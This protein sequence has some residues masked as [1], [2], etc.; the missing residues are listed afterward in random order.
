MN[1]HEGPATWE[2][3]IRGLLLGLALGDA[4]G[5][6]GSDI[7]PTG[8][9]EAGAATQ[10]AAWTTEGLLR[11]ATRYGGHVIGNPFDVVHYAYQRWATLRREKAA[12]GVPW[13]TNLENPEYRG[14]L[15]DVPAMAKKRGSSPSTIKALVQGR[16][17][18]SSGCQGMLRVLPFAAYALAP[19]DPAWMLQAVEHNA[20][21]L[22]AITHENDESWAAAGLATRLLAETLR[23][24]TSPQMAARRA[25][26]GGADRV[27][28][29]RIA[30][31]HQLGNAEPCVPDHLEALAPKKTAASALAGGMYVALSFPEPDTVAEAIEFAGWAPDGDSVAAVAGAVLGAVHGYEALPVALTSRLELGW[32][33]D[34][35]ARDLARQVA[36][37]QAGAGWKSEAPD[38]RPPL[39]PWWDTRYPGV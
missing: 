36:E 32:V 4:I 17:V 34:Q 28:E 20:R 1:R 38:P 13:H 15:A 22:V 11:A 19:G 18:D 16:G 39:D 30:S 5:S 7:P 6:K 21:G 35:L 37:N 3:K 29:A 8:P 14:W 10:L 31:A 27:I 12:P 26:S 9:L 33:M 2:S 23:E 24:E 25:L